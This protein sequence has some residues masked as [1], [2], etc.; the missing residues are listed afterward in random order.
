MT[1]GTR[2]R[3]LAACLVATA[4]LCAPRAV[5]AQ[6]AAVSDAATPPDANAA[7]ER[8][9][10][11]FTAAGHP[12]LQLGSL[13]E[14]RFRGRAEGTWRTATAD[15]GLDADLG[16][17]SRRL[18][19]EGTLFKKLEFEV[20][21][22]FG[23]PDEPERDAFVNYRFARRV[24]VQAG[25]FKMPF[26]RD[27]LT[28]GANLDFVYR[29]L[30]GREVAPGR[31]VGLMVHGRLRKRTVSYQAGYF[32]RDGDNART[33]QTRGGE[34]AV[35]GRVVV[36]PFARH[37]DSVWAP[38]QIGVAAVTSRLDNQLGLR[39]RTVFHDGVFFDRVYVNGRRLRRGVDALWAR[40]PV[41]LSAERATVV[42]DRNAMSFDGGSLPRVRAAGWYVAGTWTLTGEAK[43]G[44]VEPR[45]SLFDVGLGAIQL[46]AR[47]ERLAFGGLD[48][49]GAGPSPFDTALSGNADRVTTVGVSWFLSRHVKVQANG[50]VET[51][52]DPLRSPSPRGNGRLPRG[53]VQLQFVL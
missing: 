33:P 21:R 52:E 32:K 47:I 8:R 5:R 51:V 18:Q 24:E 7:A 19:V 4:M 42:D 17:Q 30:V 22:E 2:A 9:G 38:L 15:E 29:S 26:G 16:W 40:G 48:T 39:G 6:E 28:G 1:P 31:D 46:A 20:S 35:A 11:R 43:D 34:D 53:V 23:D 44:R 41:S 45:A 25:Q 37:A 12:V 3:R 36:E 27:A 13:G 14:I 49:A 10:L 50:V